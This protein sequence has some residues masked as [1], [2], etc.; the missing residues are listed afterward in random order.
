MLVAFLILTVSFSSV[1]IHPLLA[2]SNNSPSISVEKLVWNGSSYAESTIVNEN[3]IVEFKIVIYNPFDYYEIHWSG[4]IY[5]Q[6]PCNLQ[7]INGSVADLPL[8]YDHPELDPEQY[9]L[10]NNTVIW[11]VDR[12]SP[13]LPH[14]YLNFTYQAKAKCCGSEYLDNTLTVSPDQ[15]I[16]TCDPS[17]ILYNDGS[18]D[19]S[20]SA[21]VK[22]ICDEPSIQIIKKVKDNGLWKDETTIFEGETV[23]FRLLITNDG[24]ENLSDVQVTDTLPS[25]LSYNNDANLTPVS[26]TAHQITWQIDELL[27][28]ESVEITFS[29]T[30][31]AVGEADN[32]CVVDSC[33]GVTD[34][35]DAHIIISG[36]IVE[37]RIWNQQSHHWVDEL[38]VS[39]G[40]TIRFQIMVSYIGNGSY[41]LYNIHIRD[42]LPECLEYK[43][44]ADPTET[45]I[46]ADGKTIWWNLSTHVPAGDHITVEFDALVTETSGCG[47]CI[48]RANVSAHECSGHTFIKEDTATVNAEC[49][50]NADAGG[51]YCGDPCEQIFIEG[52]A[53]GGSAPYTYKWDLDDDG[54][55]DDYTGKSF[56]FS[57]STPNTYLISLKVTDSE[58][59]TDVDTTTVTIYPPDNTGPKTPSVPVGET[60]GSINEEYFYSTSTIDSDGDLIRYGW[61]WNGDGRVDEWTGFFV[62][63]ETV[64]IGHS[65]SD[66]GTYPVKVK[67][68]DEHGK[69]SDF[70]SSLS[71][72]IGEN[73]APQK[74][75]LVGPSRGR[76]GVSHSFSSS[77]TDPEGDSL[78]YWFDWGDGTNSGWKGPYNSGQT[79]TESHVWHTK[80]SYSIKVKAKDASGLESVWSDSITAVMPKKEVFSAYP[81]LNI[82]EW[83]AQLIPSFSFFLSTLPY[84][85]S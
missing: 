37:K 23:E 74:P 31:L 13:I 71:V 56:Y 35:D 21:S 39:V 79:V 1:F 16:N 61:D 75:I 15:L 2:T 4:I 11:Q 58:Y 62:S 20:D 68:E 33:Q 41:T 36:M 22:V 42:D 52:H 50:I 57:W 3:E 55:F 19:S 66:S 60:D 65:W 10:S 84:Y 40:D 12:E 76:T 5:D 64:S 14:Q 51:P 63:S 46:S 26:S 81:S 30:G 49:P 43:N 38:E 27:I 70:S 69:Q 7:Y 32:T 72:S 47:P 82:L 80:G 67:A 9:Y 44:N 53:S 77:T 28:N 45:A 29:A 54:F 85:H 34:E 59:R 24:Q 83:L 8:E 73:L 17:D 18:Y 6:L 25:I 78:Y 48:N